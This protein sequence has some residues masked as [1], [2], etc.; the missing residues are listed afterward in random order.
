MTKRGMSGRMAF[1][2]GLVAGVVLAAGVGVGLRE[3]DVQ[4]AAGTATLAAAGE[5]VQAPAAGRKNSSRI[6][7]EN[8]RVRV[9]EAIFY[10]EDK[11]PGPHTH[12][13]AHVGVVIEGGTMDFKSPD[14]TVEKMTLVAGGAGYRD[15]NVTHEPINTGTKP[16]KVIEVELK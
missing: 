1:C 9:K 11:H 7:L 4:A 3:A 12:D 10:P 15:A 13:L 14:G 16:V 6:V 8:A 2:A 5:M